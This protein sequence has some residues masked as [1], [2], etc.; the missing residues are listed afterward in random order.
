MQT[1]LQISVIYRSDEKNDI[2]DFDFFIR[3][4]PTED[5]NIV[6][7][8]AVP[9][10]SLNGKTV[11]H[12]KFSVSSGKRLNAY[13]VLSMISSLKELETIVNNTAIKTEDAENLL[14]ELMST[15][16]EHFGKE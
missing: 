2:N 16:L 15:Q 9:R 5:K 7:V 6:S 14:K 4:V 13:E 12:I 3:M 8:N 11:N 10:F 1:E